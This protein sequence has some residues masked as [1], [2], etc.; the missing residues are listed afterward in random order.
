M[1]RSSV[2][3]SAL[4]PFHHLTIAQ[5]QVAYA[6]NLL[7]ETFFNLFVLTMNLE[8]P[9][10][11]HA[12]KAKF[13]PY[14]L[15][16]WHVLQNDRQQRQLAI[17]AIENLPT[18]LDIKGGIARLKWAQKQANTLA[19]YRNLIVH[20]PMK[21]SWGFKDDKLTPPFAQ[22]GG[23]STKPSHTKQLRLIKSP[24]FWK[25]LRNDLLNLND[26]IDFVTRQ[27]AWREYERQNGAA[28]LGALHSWPRKP[29]LPCVR[30]IEMMRMTINR[31]AGQ[32]PSRGRRRRPSGGRPPK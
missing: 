5:G 26:Y 21:F 29:R 3:D 6:H 12:Q 19:D 9:P 24:R 27:I 10:M 7:Q 4:A 22:I 25:A 1:K 23:F 28:V 31:Q 16:M 11:S 8:R 32:A 20:A 14:S 13:Y 2:W 17:A 30:R 15:A 18:T